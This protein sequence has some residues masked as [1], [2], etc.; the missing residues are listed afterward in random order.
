MY[1]GISGLYGC[2]G[3]VSVLDGVV[4]ALDGVVS[5]LDGVGIAWT[6]N[7]PDHVP[8]LDDL[9]PL[10]V[11]PLYLSWPGFFS[12]MKFLVKSVSFPS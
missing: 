7:D 6:I 12:M 1:V 5:A 10:F 3:V 8:Y 2:S 11:V 4:S 9:I